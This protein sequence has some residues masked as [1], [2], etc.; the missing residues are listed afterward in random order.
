MTNSTLAQL[1]QTFLSALPHLVTNST[2]SQ[3]LPGLDEDDIAALDLPAP[4]VAPTSTSSYLSNIKTTSDLVLW[5]ARRGTDMV[6]G[7]AEGSDGTAI[8]GWTCLEGDVNDADWKSDNDKQ[9]DR[10]SL[11]K[12]IVKEMTQPTWG[13]W[14]DVFV[15]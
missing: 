7:P 6:A 5:Q 3:A 14:V 4:T 13:R 12:R 10:G 8:L 1:K 2:E 11:L 15:R 9:G